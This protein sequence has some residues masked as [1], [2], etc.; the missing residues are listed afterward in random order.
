MSLAYLAASHPRAGDPAGRGRLAMIHAMPEIPPGAGTDRV[1]LNHPRLDPDQSIVPRRDEDVPSAPTARDEASS[2]PGRRPPLD[3]CQ[4]ARRH[5]KEWC[6]PPG[7]RRQGV[8]PAHGQTARK[9][10]LLLA[11]HVSAAQA[12]RRAEREHLSLS[13]PGTAPIERGASASEVAPTKVGRR[14]ASP[15]FPRRLSKGPTNI[16]RAGVRTKRDS[17]SGALR[18][19]RARPGGS[20]DDLRRPQRS[21]RPFA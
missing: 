7:F 1:R 11:P 17:S 2:W 5:S 10:P 14:E 16:R 8:R 9:I 20:S 13:F 19:T 12:Q 21:G 3:Q 15:E 4:V 18:E 6:D